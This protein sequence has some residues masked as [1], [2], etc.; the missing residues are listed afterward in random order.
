[1]ALGLPVDYLQCHGVSVEEVAALRASGLASV[2][3]VCGVRPAD[4]GDRLQIGRDRAMFIM[5]AA[6]NEVPR[7]DAMGSSVS[8]VAMPSDFRGVSALDLLRQRSNVECIISL[9]PDL[10]TIMG[11]GCQIGQITELCGLPG[12]GKTQLCMELACTVQI[13]KDLHGVEGE[14]VYID[15]EGGMMPLRLHQMAESLVARLRGQ[16][17]SATSLSAESLLRRV[18]VYRVHSASEQLAVV[19][20]L[21]AFLDEHPQ[22]RLLVLDSVA[23]HMRHQIPDMM[24]RTRL[25][26]T[27]GQQLACLAQ[28]RNVAV[29]ITN[30]MTTASD[31]T[32]VPALGPSWAHVANTRLILKRV[33]GAG[34]RATIVKSPSQKHDSAEFTVTASGIAPVAP[35]LY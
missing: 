1:M 26:A 2:D 34:R 31:R 35:D 3:D 6:R 33:S 28:S 4:L 9:C 10:D 30:Q 7:G 27:L 11:G 12:V 17:P 20:A 14:A 13:P 24:L 5:K 15:A 25:L 16:S 18:H 21:P 22:V 19:R 23:F 29:V 8:S 32:L